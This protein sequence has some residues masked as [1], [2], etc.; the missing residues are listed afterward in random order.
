MRRRRFPLPRSRGGPTRSALSCVRWTNK[1]P[2]SPQMKRIEQELPPLSERLAHR[3]EQTQQTIGSRHALG[4]LDALMDFW[5][6]SRGGL[7]AWLATVTERAD[8]LEQQ[9]AELA[10]LTATWA[11]TRT[12][13][14]S[15]RVPPELSQRIMDVMAAL[16]GAQAR[17][18]AERA[19]TLVLQ[20]RVARELTR[21]DGVPAHIAQ[22]RRQAAGGL[23]CGTARRSGAPRSSFCRASSC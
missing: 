4:T 23:P 13:V 14:R 3:F 15:A 10:K 9:R 16:V 17:V 20:D 21:I 8:W 7:S 12:E 6:S 18:E 11:R 19:A 5:R 1:L 22:A 2:A